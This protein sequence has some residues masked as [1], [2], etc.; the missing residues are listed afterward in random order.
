MAERTDRAHLY[1]DRAIFRVSGRDNAMRVDPSLPQR[2][3]CLPDKLVPVNDEPHDLVAMLTRDLD[4]HRR[5]SGTRWG[6][7]RAADPAAPTHP[8]RRGWFRL[9]AWVDRQLPRPEQRIEPAPKLHP[10]RAIHSS[11]AITS[12]WLPGR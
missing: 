10:A 11:I 3:G 1:S 9:I 2:H 12:A 4:G 6:R 7:H 5:F 8:V